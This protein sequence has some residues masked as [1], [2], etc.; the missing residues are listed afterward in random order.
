MKHYILVWLNNADD[1]Q[2]KGKPFEG[3]RGRLF[4]EYMALTVS[5]DYPEYIHEVFECDKDGNILEK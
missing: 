2:G 3:E 1:K 4:L 5:L